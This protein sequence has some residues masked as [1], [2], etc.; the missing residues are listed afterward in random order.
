MPVPAAP[1]GYGYGHMMWG[2]P[3]WGWHPFMIVGPIFVLLACNIIT[4]PRKDASTE[5]DVER[6]GQNNTGAAVAR[7]E[8]DIEHQMEMVLHD[9]ELYRAGKGERSAC[10]ALCNV[11]LT[12]GFTFETV[13][14]ADPCVFGKPLVRHTAEG[15]IGPAEEHRAGAEGGGFNLSTG[16]DCLPGL[17][18]T[19]HK[20]AHTTRSLGQAY[21][22]FAKK[23]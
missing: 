6:A 3:G 16:G 4:R 17:R 8:A 22:S 9:W 7:V 2:G 14:I 15:T 5:K 12:S 23:R 1:Y 13:G 19:D 21:W 11:S 20:H 18:A 10:R